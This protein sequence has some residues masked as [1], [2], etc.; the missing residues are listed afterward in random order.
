MPRTLTK[1]G[2]KRALIYTRVSQDKSGRGRSPEE[3]EAEARAECARRGWTVVDVITDN[4]RSAS[5]YARKSRP[6]YQEMQRRLVAGEADVVVAWEG[7]RFQRDLGAYAQLASL[8]R[9]QGVFYSYS[10]RVFDLDDPD[11]EFQATLDAALSV[12]ESGVTRKRV[13][14]TMAAAAE[15]GQ[16]HGR[17]QYGYRRVYDARTG[18]LL[19]QEPDPEKAPVV[20]LV[21]DRIAKGASLMLL[22]D[23]LNEAGHRTGTGRLWDA[24]SLRQLV[25]DRP[26]YLGQRTHH[27]AVVAEGGWPALVDQRT[28]DVV[29][30]LLA[31]R[32]QGGRAVETKWLLSGLLVC[33]E[34]GGR[35]YVDPRTSDPYPAPR[36]VC[37]GGVVPGRRGCVSRNVDRVDAAVEALVVERLSRPD[38]LDAFRP[39]VM[40]VGEAQA[41]LDALRANLAEAERVW[42]DGGLSDRAFGLKEARLAPEIAALEAEV[43]AGSE[44]LPPVLERLTRGDVAKRWKALAIADRRAVVRV[45]FDELRLARITSGG[46]RWN[47]D[48]GTLARW[49]GDDEPRPLPAPPAAG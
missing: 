29:Q 21:F 23:E 37:R 38:A 49:R 30:G 18:A 4:D 6:G 46:H 14:R 43:R 39:D 27:G 45:L 44:P 10:G 12:R 8:C 2:T 40:G 32:S 28:Y 48:P 15:A 9:E 3:Q 36:Y 41:H 19:G 26:A 13:K 5:R 17:V 22:A 11:D 31:R 24:N 25:Q 20:R 42:L 34:C 7:S 35:V 1:T 47:T 16:V 33:D